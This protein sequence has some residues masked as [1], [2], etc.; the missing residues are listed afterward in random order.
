MEC[1]TD[2]TDKTDKNETKKIIKVLTS[3]S[4]LFLVRR[5]KEIGRET[6]LIRP[7]R[8]F[9]SAIKRLRADGSSD[10]PSVVSGKNVKSG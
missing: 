2:K 5:P 10:Y 8:I 9:S 7:I 3:R 6:R 1:Q 4:D